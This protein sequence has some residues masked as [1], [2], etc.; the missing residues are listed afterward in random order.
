MDLTLSPSEEGFRDEVRTWLLANNP[1]PEPEGGLD[2]VMAFRREWQLKLHAAGWAGISWPKEY[3]GRG[4]TMIEQAIFVGEA[5]RQEAPSPANV[6]GLAMGGPVV[7]AHGTDAQKQRYLEPILTGEEIWCQGFSEPESGSDLASL[8]TRAVKDGDEWVVSGQ[9]VWTT[10]AQYAKWCMLVARTDPDAPKHQGLTYFLMDMEQEGV[11]AKPLVQITGEGEFNE[12]FIDEARIP[13]ENVVGGVGNGWGVAITTLMNERAGLA[14]GAIAQI[15]NSLSRLARLATEVR[16]NG[17]SAADD[18]Y[19]RQRI[20]QL[21]IEAETMRLAAYRGLTKTMQSG[22][23]GPE[24]SLGK[25]QWVGHQPGSE[26]AGAG[27]RGRLRAALARRRAGDRQRRL[28]VRLP[29]LARQLDRGRHD[30]HPQEHHRRAGARPA[31]AA[32]GADADLCTSISPTSSRRSSRP[33][34]TSSPRA[35]N[36]SGSGRSPPART[37]STPPAGARW[38]SSA[39]PA[40]RC[41]E[42]WGGQ[43]LGIVELAVLFEEMGYALA[44]SPL[45]S[46]TIVG[47][48]LTLCGSDD[49]RERFLRPLAEGKLRGA[50]ALWDAGSPA[51]IG[52]FTMEARADGDGI[53]L[54]GLKTLVPD[55]AGADFFLVATSDGRRHLVEAGADGVTVTAE[56]SIDPTRRFSSVSF[57]GVRVAAA[58]SLP[59]GGRRLLRRL[60]PPLRRAGGRVDRDRPADDGDGGR[61]RQR[62]PAVRPPDRRLPGRLPPLRADAAGDR[63]RPLRRLR[64]RLGRRRR[65]RVAAARRLDGQ[66]LRLRR[67]LARPRRLDPGPRRD[68]LHLG[69]RP[70]LLPQARPRQRGDLRRRQ[71]APRTRRR[72]GASPAPPRRPQPEPERWARSIGSPSPRSAPRSPTSR[73]ETL[74]AEAAGVEC[75]WAPEL[76]RSAVTQAA[77]L[78]AQDRADRRR[79]RDR[80]GLHP[81]PLHPRGHRARHRRDVRR[82][83]PPRDGRRGQTAERNLAQRRLRQAGAAPARGDRGDPADH[84]PGERRRA[85]PLRGRVLRHRHQGLGAPAPGAARGGADLHRRACRA[86]WRGW[87][88]TSPTA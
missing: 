33:R 79:H 78:A 77:Y 35:S 73:T 39:G 84:A 86:G 64:R 53:V 16:T 80:L 76:F 57:E 9:K 48:A 20:A 45:F 49:Q 75:V 24:G 26:R 34:T 11:E 62:P 23:P 85:D 37:A 14:F 22:I 66:G 44:P 65:A 25:W 63:E 40:W 7:I 1:G 8:K 36:P 68:R 70:P 31:E 27:D 10:F 30:R 46:N 28:A 71:V 72:R 87:P 29:A 15:Q 4:A 59:G 13:E 6:L 61:V 17:G 19:Y 42:E 82:A 41:P 54:D 55:A 56:P 83:L 3:G 32:L 38:P 47:L 12:V 2:E 81:Q 67:R 21:N 51:T 58:D 18:A 74:R 60:P 43:G 5:A 50:P 88:A 69:A 52:E